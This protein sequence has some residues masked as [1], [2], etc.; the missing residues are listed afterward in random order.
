MLLNNW[1]TI[2]ILFLLK[3]KQVM[4]NYLNWKLTINKIAMENPFPITGNT[5]AGNLG[6][7]T[8]KAIVSTLIETGIL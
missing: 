1:M 4:L 2:N 3:K 5:T 6:L 8:G 7:V